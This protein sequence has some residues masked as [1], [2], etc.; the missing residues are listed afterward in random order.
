[1][2]LLIGLV[3]VVAIGAAFRQPLVVWNEN[4]EER[5][6]MFELPIEDL[7]APLWKVVPFK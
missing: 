5:L 6:A 1:M 7:S 3:V 2:G 4:A